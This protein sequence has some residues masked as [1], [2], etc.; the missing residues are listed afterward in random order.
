[1]GFRRRAG[2]YTKAF[3]MLFGRQTIHDELLNLRVC[4][5]AAYDF[6]GLKNES[7]VRAVTTTIRNRRTVNYK[8]T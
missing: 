1:M 7:L 2:R 4:A 5:T 3:S 8:F 6:E